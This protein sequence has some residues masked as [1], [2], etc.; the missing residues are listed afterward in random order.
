MI[1]GCMLHFKYKGGITM[2]KLL[3]F[4]CVLL[5]LA[6]MLGITAGA[7]MTEAEKLAEAVSK[8]SLPT[9]ELPLADE[10]ITLTLMYPKTASHGDFDD[11]FF[12]NAVE[13]ATGIR[14]VVQGIDANGW[15][16]K[17]ALSI[18]SG[19]YGEIFINGISFNDAAQYGQAGIFK[20]MED[21]LEK[22]APNAMSILNT[23]PETRRNV[24]S[25]DGH[26]YMMAAY[27]GTPR[28]M[29]M[30]GTYVQPI[31]KSWLDKLGL[32][33]P[34]TLDELYDTLK[35]FKE[36]D[37]N[38]NGD[39]DEVPL[40]F[41][42]DGNGYNMMLGAFG[43]VNLRHDI[44]DGE[45]V[46]V[47]IQE[48]F[49]HYLEFMRK[50]YADG[51]MDQNIFTQT[52]E[53]FQAKYAEGNIGFM[54]NGSREIMGR[55]MFLDCVNIKPLVSEYNETPVHPGRAQEVD[56][57]G[58]VITDKCSD[59]KA[60]LAVKL[61]DYFYSEEGTYLIK[62]GP[63]YGVWGDMID[64]GYVRTTTE[65]GKSTYELVYDK[66]KYNNSY[67]N[68]RIENGLMN[69][70]FFYTEAH[71]EVIIGGDET[72]NHITKMVYDSDMLSARRNGYPQM[73]TFTEDE[74]DTI[75]SYV[76]MDSY[77]DQMVAKFI[78]GEI[79]L[80]DETWN[81]YKN[82][83]NMMDLDSLVQVR[84]EAFDRWNSK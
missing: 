8:M 72:N 57:Y 61:L 38:G 73:V 32:P 68:F 6:L 29:L 28:D 47:P 15:N 45:Y 13:A 44:I 84:Q 9:P 1:L 69:M 40:S 70:P 74:Q 12:M 43:F 18:A 27:D 36:E 55:E 80:N 11:M 82:N 71:A 60:I 21:L 54:P 19:D 5:G 3:L 10:T 42:Y 22:H 17:L 37:P 79:E 2:K 23:L 76:L 26:I 30:N 62:C 51:L 64:G 39:K 34:S 67:W 14:L 20:P 41:V 83:I 4:L 65:D 49:R 16:E 56:R 81:S 31:Q 63:E 77:V 46:Y 35:A 33:V 48:N 53:M 66:E 58:L 24:T 52:S 7:E 25:T 50:L 75:A 78:T 59:E